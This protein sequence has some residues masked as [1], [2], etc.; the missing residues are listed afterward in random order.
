MRAI[1]LLHEFTISDKK[2][3]VKADAKTQE[4][5]DEYNKNIKSGDGD[6][7][8]LDEEDK[9]IKGQLLYV[10]REHEIELSKEPDNK[11]KKNRHNKDKDPK[12]E[13]STTYVF[14]FY[15]L[16]LFISNFRIY[17]IWT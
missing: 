12:L 8:D 13:V 6:K 4:K 11:E 14:C 7:N 2:L 1:R 15:G 16:R 9:I 10:L 17:L 5:L 3:I